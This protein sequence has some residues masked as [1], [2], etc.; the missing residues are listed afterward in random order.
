MFQ[1]EFYSIERDRIPKKLKS[2]RIYELLQMK[3][4]GIVWISGPDGS[5][6]SKQ[7]TNLVSLALDST[8]PHAGSILRQGLS[9]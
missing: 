3:S 9:S 2:E 5:R 1:T 6:G 7:N 8:F 4:V